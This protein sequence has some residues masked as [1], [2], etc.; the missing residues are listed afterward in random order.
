MKDS[1]ERFSTAAELY[2]RYRPD[3][4]RELIDWI[5]ATGGLKKGDAVAD[6][7]CGTGISSRALAARGLNVTGV[8]PNDAMLAFAKGEK[9][10][11]LTYVK[12]SAEKTG[13]PDH[14]FAAATVAQAFHWFNV[15]P[16]LKELGRVLKPGARCF[17]FWNMRTESPMNAEYEALLLKFSTEYKEVTARATEGTIKGSRTEQEVKGSKQVRD[18]KDAEFPN[19]QVLDWDGFEGRVFSSSYVQHGVADPDG[20]KTALRAHF[21][22]FSKKD[23]ITI[24]YRVEAWCFAIR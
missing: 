2:H 10:P 20:L 8:E 21:D 24:A 15:E 12:G 3:Y 16:A 7:G 9:Q 18:W 14:A 13:L 6:V 23:K 22:R 19:K 17:A 5:V 1:K 4:P 11:N